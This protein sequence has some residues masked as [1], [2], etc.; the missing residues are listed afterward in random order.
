VRPADWTAASTI[1][2]AFRSRTDVRGLLYRLSLLLWRDLL[3]C[4]CD[5]FFAQ[6]SRN[7]LKGIQRMPR[8]F[9]ILIS[10]IAR[11]RASRAFSLSCAQLDRIFY[12]GRTS[13]AC[14]YLFH[15]SASGCSGAKTRRAA[16][17]ARSFIGV[18]P[19]GRPSICTAIAFGDATSISS[20]DKLSIFGE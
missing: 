16:G 13:Q 15:V 2:L 8:L 9:G 7:F 1:T 17:K 3:S 10:A 6:I 18:S 11:S 12:C 19:S 20:A 14:V 4:S 5:I